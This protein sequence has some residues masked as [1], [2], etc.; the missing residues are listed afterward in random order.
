[1][2][3]EKPEQPLEPEIQDLVQLSVV[4]PFLNEEEALPSLLEEVRVTLGPKPGTPGPAPPRFEVIA[5]N[6]GSTDGTGPLL[7]RLAGDWPALRVLH[8]RRRCGQSAALAGG[9]SAARG[10]WIATLDGDGQS[11]PADIPRLLAAREGFEM[12]TGIRGQ[13]MDSA[14][15]RISSRVAYRVRDA[16]LHD[17]IVDT[18]CSTR[19]LRR[20]CLRFLPLQFRGLH[21]FLPALFQIAG[22]RVQQVSVGHRPR[23]GGRPKYGI[24]NRMIPGLVDLWAVRWMKS[25]YAP[26]DR[27]T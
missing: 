2:E 13:R 24:G 11:D 23:K 4:I 3:P 1:M 15:R 26:P 21:R 8:F 14:I 17:G 25:R 19:V 9:F 22:Y 20:E 10:E 6:D 18:G 27:W 5:V 12:V 7:D 16:V